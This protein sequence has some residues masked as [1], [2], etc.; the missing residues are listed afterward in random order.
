LLVLLQ[1]SFAMSV[2]KKLERLRTID[3]LI[4]TKATGQPVS[5]AAKLGISV[6]TLQNDLSDLKELGCSP[7]FCPIRES[8]I[9]EDESNLKDCL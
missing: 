9:Y 6:R 1:N 7:Y 3:R 2:L 4:Q 8:Y 5:L